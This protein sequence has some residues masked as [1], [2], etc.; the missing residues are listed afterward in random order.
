ML[1]RNL[2][3]KINLMDGLSLEQNVFE[4]LRNKTF[5]FITFFHQFPRLSFEHLFPKA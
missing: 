5:L 3:D 2:D 4:T 1:C